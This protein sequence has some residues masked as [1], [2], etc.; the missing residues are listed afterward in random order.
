M[1]TL[2][3]AN[4]RE[5]AFKGQEYMDA[6]YQDALTDYERKKGRWDIVRII[7]CIDDDDKADWIT[8]HGFDFDDDNP[9]REHE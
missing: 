3:W 2:Q 8:V 5:L 9:F 6:Q 1:I 7:F 4:D